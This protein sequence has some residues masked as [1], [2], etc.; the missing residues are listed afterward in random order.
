MLTQTF[1]TESGLLFVIEIT[2]SKMAREIR[3][4][5]FKCA[6]RLERCAGFPL[7][8]ELVRAI[9]WRVKGIDKDCWKY[10]N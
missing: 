3:A 6:A 9:F 7:L 10:F 4:Q 5:D 2:F 8:C 1:F